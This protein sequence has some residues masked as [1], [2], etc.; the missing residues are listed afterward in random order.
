M[1]VE[2]WSDFICPYCYIGTE[3]F[4]RALEK[5]EHRE[6]VKVEFKCFQL[7]PHKLYEES[8]SVLEILEAKHGLDKAELTD[9]VRSIT[10]MGKELGLYFRWD[11]MKYANSFD[12][13]RL[14]KYAAKE[15]KDA[16]A[17]H[18][19]FERH[20][21]HNEN[22]GEAEV[23]LDIAKE[24]S[25]NEE[26][27]DELLCFNNFAKAVREDMELAEDMG[28]EG[29]PFFIFNEKY[30]LSG[31]QAEEIFLQALEQVWEEEKD[32]I[33]E[34]SKSAPI[35]TPTYCVGDECK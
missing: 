3:K 18:L 25:L 22:I 29:V 9:L 1:K 35:C 31:V 5:F 4:D 34:Q 23:L 2:I 6:Y 13:H 33:L 8:G 32:T 16:A 21:T 15:E 7:D 20:F 11:K 10:D 19:L 14:I 27:V 24:L 26:E 17:K 28:I 30:A 12:A